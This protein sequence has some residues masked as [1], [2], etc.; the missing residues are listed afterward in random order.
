MAVTP[1][2]QVYSNVVEFEAMATQDGMLCTEGKWRSFD[3]KSRGMTKF[4]MSL[5]DGIFRAAPMK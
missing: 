4:R 2:K 1:S 3:G 5:K